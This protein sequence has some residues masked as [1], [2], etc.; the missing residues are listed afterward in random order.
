MRIPEE[1]RAAILAGGYDPADVVAYKFEDDE[2]GPPKLTFRLR[3][4]LSKV[5]V[6]IT[7]V[8]IPK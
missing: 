6:E 2:S 5:H 1:I 7:A 4:D 8:E 3:P